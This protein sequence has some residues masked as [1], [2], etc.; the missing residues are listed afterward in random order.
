[1]F[2]N[3]LNKNKWRR[4]RSKF[5]RYEILEWKWETIKKQLWE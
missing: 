1:M 2:F 5:K 4:W 3:S